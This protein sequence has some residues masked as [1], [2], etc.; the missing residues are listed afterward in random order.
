MDLRLQAYPDDKMGEGRKTELMWFGSHLG[1]SFLDVGSK[2]KRV[3][4]AFLLSLKPRDY[5]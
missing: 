1:N 5:Y 3:W 2:A 4:I